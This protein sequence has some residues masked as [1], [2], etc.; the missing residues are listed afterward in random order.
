MDADALVFVVE[1]DAPLRESLKN[2]IRSVR[3]RV[4]A[5][6]SAQEFLRSPRPDVPGC[7]VLDVRLQR[8]IRLRRSEAATSGPSTPIHATCAIL[9]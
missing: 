3:L 1:D 4:E 9:L 5:F 6:S 2:L 7:L 8:G